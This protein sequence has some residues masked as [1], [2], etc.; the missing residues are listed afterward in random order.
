[1]KEGDNIEEMLLQNKEALVKYA[2]AVLHK[3]ISDEKMAVMPREIRAIAGFIAEYARKYCA[4]KEASLVGGFIML[5]LIN[6][7]LVAPESYG[8]LPLG[9]NPSAKAR[10]N[11]IL[12]S[13]LLQNLSNDVEFG[14]KEPHMAVVNE[15]IVG[16][17]D[18][19]IEFLRKVAT[20][21]LAEEGKEEWADCKTLVVKP[22]VDITMLDL[23]ELNFLH[24]LL[25]QYREELVKMLDEEKKSDVMSDTEYDHAM[26]LFKCLD[27][28]GQN[29]EIKALLNQ[30]A[31]VI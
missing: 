16:N 31:K 2:T 3:I 12:L 30:E 25:V 15:F 11:L 22:I 20:D 7:S 26:L 18:V 5:R 17:R 8:M 27:S 1:M 23:K 21:P 29:R 4:D 13:K 9:K 24:R 10:R 6:P 14:V 28:L 19:M